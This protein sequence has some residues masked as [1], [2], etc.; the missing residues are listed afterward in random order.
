MAVKTKTGAGWLM[1]FLETLPWGMSV[2][3]PFLGFFIRAQK[4]RKERK[5]ATRQSFPCFASLWSLL[6]PW[7]LCLNFPNCDKNFSNQELH[8]I[9]TIALFEKT[10]LFQCPWASDFSL[11][12]EGGRREALFHLSDKGQMSLTCTCMSHRP[13]GCC[14][15]FV[16]DLVLVLLSVTN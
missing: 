4:G 1:V 14:C 12:Y 13:V 3:S 2:K 5:E 11:G 15:C 9:Q 10:K 6:V 7:W 8:Q 16:E